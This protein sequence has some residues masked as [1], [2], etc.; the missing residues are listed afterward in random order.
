MIGEERSFYFLKFP[1]AAI[2]EYWTSPKNPTGKACVAVY[3]GDTNASEIR[4]RVFSKIPRSE[5]VSW[6]NLKLNSNHA[7]WNG[8]E[9]F[10]TAC[11]Q[12]PENNLFVVFH[13]E[14]VLFL[15]PVSKIEDL[16]EDARNEYI[17]RWGGGHHSPPWPKICYVDEVFPRGD[18]KRYVRWELPFVLATSNANQS[19]NRGTCRRYTQVF[20]LN[21]LWSLF[22]KTVSSP[23]E[24]K[25]VLHNLGPIELETL[26]F[27][28]LH[29]RG[30]FCPANRGS[31]IPDVDIVVENRA[32]ALIEDHGLDQVKFDK[33]ATTFQVKHDVDSIPDNGVDY[34][35]ALR[36]PSHPKL[37][38]ARWLMKATATNEKCFRWVRNALWWTGWSSQTW[39]A[40]QSDY[41]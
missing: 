39:E 7:G 11:E 26:L 5:N 25:D 34:V 38:D 18:N 33:V 32:T 19:F 3:F 16:S 31:T 1:S 8:L 4:G 37:R 27:L 10:F 22:G 21:A 6:L 41:A 24:A 17:K 30:H 28:N 23:K 15:K 9:A 40:I 35:V 20:H 13:Q 14:E 2:S 36:G 29:H 12:I